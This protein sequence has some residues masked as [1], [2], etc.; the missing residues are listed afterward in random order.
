MDERVHH[1]FRPVLKDNK[2]SVGWVNG[3]SYVQSILESRACKKYALDQAI[4]RPSPF[5]LE[6]YFLALVFKEACTRKELVSSQVSYN[7]GMSEVYAVVHI[8]AGIE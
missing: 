2:L 5:E 1:M 3:A 6:L 4:S 7:R 8:G